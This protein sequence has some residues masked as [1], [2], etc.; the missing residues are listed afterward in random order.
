MKL[1]IAIV[2][3]GLVVANGSAYWSP[4][5]ISTLTTASSDIVIGKVISKK[6]DTKTHRVRIKV[7][8]VEHLKGKDSQTELEF[9]APFSMVQDVGTTN[10]FPI[11]SSSYEIGETCVIFLT[12]E[13]SGM[14][15]TR[16]D[17]GKFI[18]ENDKW[19]RQYSSE[20]SASLKELRK[21][22][23]EAE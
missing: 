23:A 4:T 8:V 20:K 1:H 5:P 22:I 3:A 9:D 2:A 15:M 17:D 6:D 10:L 19:R 16:D 12:R 7:K 18:V 14:R 11:P 13:K 21:A